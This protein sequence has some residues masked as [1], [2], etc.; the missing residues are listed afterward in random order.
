MKDN[1]D[2]NADFMVCKD[3]TNVLSNPL[4]IEGFTADQSEREARLSA[5]EAY[6]RLVNVR[7]QPVEDMK[8]GLPKQ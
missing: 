1:K 4:V 3:G 8:N 7:E 5:Y 6:S 2:I